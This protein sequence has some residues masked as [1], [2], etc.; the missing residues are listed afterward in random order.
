MKTAELLSGTDGA[1]LFHYFTK[2]EFKT[3]T[4]YVSE[5]Q[6]GTLISKSKV[7]D[8]DYDGIDSPSRGVI[9]AVADF[10]SFKVK[11]IVADDYTKYSTDFP[12]LGQ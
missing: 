2:D 9:A 6:S 8:L 4:I 12:I 11:L 5:Y 7:A 3:L 10:E 1:Y